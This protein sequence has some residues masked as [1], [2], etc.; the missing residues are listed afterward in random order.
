MNAP[1]R[2]AAPRRRHRTAPP[3]PRPA[4][5]DEAGRVL[6]RPDG[7]HWLDESGHQEFGPFPSREEALDDLDGRGAQHHEDIEALHVA[8]PE[9]DI[10][11]VHDREG[12]DPPEP[13]A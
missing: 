2:A 5:A 6:E 12:D 3:D 9:I 10:E 13:A 4:T 7:F 1:T 8:E 11:A